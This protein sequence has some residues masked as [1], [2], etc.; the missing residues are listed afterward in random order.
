M[1]RIGICDDE[2]YMLELISEK[3]KNYMAANHMDLSLLQYESGLKMLESGE[4][5][6]VIFLDIK[7]KGPDGV[8]TAKRMRAK[9]FKGHVVFIT[10]SEE[11]VYRAFKV[12]TFDYLLKPLDKEEFKHTMKRILMSF[13]NRYEGRM[14]IRHDGEWSVILFH[15]IIYAEVINRKIHLRLTDGRD[16]EYYDQL[17][18]MRERLDGRFCRCHRSYIVNSDHIAGVAHGRE[19]MMDNRDVIPIS[20]TY[21]ETFNKEYFSYIEAWCDD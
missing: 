7:M 17:K 3:I 14:L 21:S 9:G 8:E 12:E 16:I 18:R 2:A 10:V 11:D 13:R 5:F 4:K 20:R 6:D 15:D 19:L 1:I